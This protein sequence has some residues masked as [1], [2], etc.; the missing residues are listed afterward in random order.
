MASEEGNSNKCFDIGQA[1]RMLR[2]EEESDNQLR[3]QLKEKWT[4]T[5][6]EKLNGTFKTN[7]S[8]YREIL[9]NALA[10]DEVIR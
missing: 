7:A 2:E 5:A 4:R 6:S 9:N 10:A 1:E 3:A 8:R